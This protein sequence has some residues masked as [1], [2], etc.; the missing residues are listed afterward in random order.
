M[1]D[2]RPT[3][4]EVAFADV[5]DE[6]F[7]P[8]LAEAAAVRADPAEPDRFAF[9]TS[10]AD[11]LRNLFP[12]DAEPEMR[13]Q[14]R[15]LLFHAFAFWRSAKPAFSLET[16]LARYL[17]EASPSLDGWSLRLPRASVYL[18]LPANLF[19][20]STSPEA[21]PEPVDG[22]WVTADDPQSPRRLRALMVL[23]LRRGRPGFSVASVEADVPHVGAAS[24]THARGRDE[25]RD[26]ASVLPGGELGGLYSIV[27]TTEALKV[28][29]AALW[30]IDRHPDDVEP[31]GPALR[32]VKLGQLGG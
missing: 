22:F 17:V 30:Y 29:A 28:I 4:Y 18:Q 11:A 27:S 31:E 3:P 15:S 32:Q 10:V 24:W 5:E 1:P 25:G 20:A 7:P 26:F 13:D 8:I 9:L 16:A 2:A 14:L 12:E 21:T 6:L 23:G 19:W